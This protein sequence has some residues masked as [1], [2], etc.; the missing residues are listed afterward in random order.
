MV[1][2]VAALIIIAI[3]AGV[4]HSRSIKSDRADCGGGCSTCPHHSNCGKDVKK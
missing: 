4:I 1:Y 3:A 2:V